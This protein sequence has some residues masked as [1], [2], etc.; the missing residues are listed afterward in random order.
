MFFAFSSLGPPRSKP[1]LVNRLRAMSMEGEGGSRGS[2]HRSHDL[3]L[4][5][6]C[7]GGEE[8]CEQRLSSSCGAVSGP[9][10]KIKGRVTLVVDETRFIVDID[11]LKNHP[12][13]MLGR[14]VI[15]I[16]QT[17]ISLLSPFLVVFSFVKV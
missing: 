13:T 1:C 14:W 5:E 3:S 4:L 9:S 15:C 2:G 8:C 6:A 11:M 7:T 17:H 10:S 12:N 16:S